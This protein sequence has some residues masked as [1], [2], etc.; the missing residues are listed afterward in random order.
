M[1]LTLDEIVADAIQ[2]VGLAEGVLAGIKALPPAATRKLVD[3]APILCGTDQSGFL[4]KQLALI[5][6]L[7]AQLKAG[8]APGT[9]VT[10]A[11]AKAS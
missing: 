1:P 11:P 6:T 7:E 2:E 3:Y 10:T 8:A 5:D 4:Y 9:T